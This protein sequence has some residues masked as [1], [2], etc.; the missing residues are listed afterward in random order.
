M[1]QW[2]FRNRQ[3]LVIAG[4][5]LVGWVLGW[6]VGLPLW[7]LHGLLGAAGVALSPPRLERCADCP[8]RER[9]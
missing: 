3:L 5:A 9:S 4:F 1:R 7:T 8:Q 6:Y 2:S